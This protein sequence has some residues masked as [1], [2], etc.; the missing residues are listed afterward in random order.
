MAENRESPR[1][2]IV[3]DGPYG[4]RPRPQALMKH[5][6]GKSDRPVVPRNSPNKADRTAAEA[7]EGRGLAKGNPR[8]TDTARTQR[9]SKP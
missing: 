3:A 6:R 5:D 8:R 4:G 2:P 7:R 1:S 9:W